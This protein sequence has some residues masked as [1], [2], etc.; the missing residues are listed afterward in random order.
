VSETIFSLSTGGLPSG[1]AVIRVSGPQVRFV[2]ETICGFLPDVRT[3]S[4]RSFRDTDGNVIDRGLIIRFAAP[5]SFTGEDCAEFHLHGSRAV[6]AAML[7]LLGEFDGVRQAE[8]GE[9]TRQA[10][11]NGKL[12]LTEVEGLSDL[13]AAETEA[14]RR[15]AIDQAGGSLRQL[16]D[17]WMS[18]LTHG[19]AML[20]AEF[21]FSDEEDIPGTVSQQ[22]WPD[23][24]ALVAEITEHITGHHWGEVVRDGF[25]IALIGA[26]NAGKSTLLNKLADRDVAIVSAIPGTTRDTIEVRLDIGG[27]LV[28][29]RDTAG[30]RETEDEIE[31][32]GIRRTY[33]AARSSDLVLYLED[34]SSD[35]NVPAGVE[36]FLSDMTN[37]LRVDT[38]QDLWDRADDMVHS[39]RLGVSAIT[40]DG[41]DRLVG[42]IGLEIAKLEP[43]STRLPNRARHRDLLIECRRHIEQGLVSRHAGGELAAADLKKA[44]E[45]LGRI[46]GQIGVEDLLGVIFSEFCVGK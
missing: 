7:S 18:R 5:H 23:L 21:D 4:Y 13:L 26:P 34:G 6:V 14:Q 16:Y 24:D 43:S 32:E 29:I 38:K 30:L 9:F 31:S 19:R 10:F 15:A 17:G 35:L 11:A 1:I 12:D 20:E 42:R 37:V 39:G 2:V 22:I 45:S 25:R 27:F 3:A 28:L 36:D 33:D 40:G 46:T 44:A 41:I 8:A